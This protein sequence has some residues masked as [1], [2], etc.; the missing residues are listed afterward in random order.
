LW[1]TAAA[2]AFGSNPIGWALLGLSAIS[3]GAG[4]ASNPDACEW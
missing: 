2:L 1:G 3:L 4:F